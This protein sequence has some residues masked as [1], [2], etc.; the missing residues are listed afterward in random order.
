MTI[1]SS[2]LVQDPTQETTARV[3]A[4]ELTSEESESQIEEREIE[5]EQGIPI[6][7]KKRGKMTVSPSNLVEDPIHEAAAKAVE[8]KHSKAIIVFQ[9]AKKRRQQQ[10]LRDEAST[11]AASQ[12]ETTRRQHLAEHYSLRSPPIVATT[13]ETSNLFYV[14]ILFPCQFLGIET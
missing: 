11:A 3:V 8:Q 5:K 10:R 6:Q 4:E 1:S 13:S 12:R 9:R 2:D 14:S 7:R